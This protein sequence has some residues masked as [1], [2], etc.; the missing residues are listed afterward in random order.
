M[1]MVR[2]V[3]DIEYRHVYQLQVKRWW[4]PFYTY[5]AC[6]GK[7][8]MIEL[9]QQLVATGRLDPNVVYESAV[10]K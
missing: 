6:G 3:K 8:E 5:V 4:F 2:V 10:L 9:A 7:D 1:T